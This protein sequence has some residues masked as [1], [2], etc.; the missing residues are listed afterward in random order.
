[1][2]LSKKCGL[3]NKML[4]GTFNI[5]FVLQLEVRALLAEALGGRL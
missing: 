4:K 2:L 5:E 3:E 1:M